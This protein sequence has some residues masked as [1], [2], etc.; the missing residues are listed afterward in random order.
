MGDGLHVRLDL[1]YADFHL[2]VSLQLPGRGITA[3][4]GP[5]GSGKTS[6]LR[7]I[8]GL[9]HAS[10]AQVSLHG[11]VW[12]DS[13][14]GRFVPTHQRPL[15]Y[16]FQEANLFAH[17][18]VRRNL[19]YGFTRA[20]RR[21][22]QPPRAQFDAVVDRL[23]LAPLLDRQA[24][25][26]SGGERQRVAIGRALLANPRLLLLDEP[27]AALDTRRKDEILPYLERLHDELDIPSIYVSHSID[28]VA[29]LADHLVILERGAVIASG[30]MQQTMARLDL[31]AHLL[32]RAGVVI[33]ATVLSEHAGDHLAQLAFAGGTLWV[34]SRGQAPG[35]KLRC[36]IEARDVSLSLERQAGT[37]ILNLLPAT[38]IAVTDSAHPAQRLV[39]LD[40][41]GS[42][43][44]AQL[45]RRSWET[46]QLTPGK[47]VW[48]QI[49][50]VALIG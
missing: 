4:F 49:K 12:Q 39:Q 10:S 20:R 25:R 28:E 22:T 36:R 11:E 18:N 45:T 23:D 13:A 50:A 33:D 26:L 5:S 37:S 8:A 21:G 1:R 48:A 7:A 2:D 27:L 24:G 40:V 38:I 44:L 19:D 29:R 43:L 31:P 6:C 41:G 15:A 14:S 47:S 42:T 46:L 17:L 3:L 16:V 30:P 35:Q 34:P 9:E 32:E